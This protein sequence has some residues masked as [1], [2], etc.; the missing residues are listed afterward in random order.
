MFN[1]AI[2]SV[3]LSCIQFLWSTQDAHRT[4]ILSK[5]ALEYT[6]DNLAFDARQQKIF[7]IEP[8]AS[9]RTLEML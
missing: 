1:I 8:V 9:V 6:L 2:L 4:G 7:K 3:G 5:S